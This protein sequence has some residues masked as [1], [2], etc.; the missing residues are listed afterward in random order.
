MT[1]CYCYCKNERE[2]GRSGWPPLEL[3]TSTRI[4]VV[5]LEEV[6]ET[7]G[8]RRTTTK[9]QLKQLTMLLTDT[10]HGMQCF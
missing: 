3:V 2:E 4:V 9:Q 10:G 7:E 5:I 8:D 6:E 1:V